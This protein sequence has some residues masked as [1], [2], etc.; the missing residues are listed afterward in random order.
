MLGVPQLRVGNLYL[1]QALLHGARG[2][3]SLQGAAALIDGL[4]VGGADFDVHGHVLVAPL[5][6]HLG[7]NADEAVLAGRDL[8]RIACEVE[9]AVRGHQFHRANQSA[10][11]VP[12]RVARLASVG[13][14]G[15]DVVLAKAQLVGHVNLESHVAIVR[16]AYSG[17]VQ[18]DVARVHDALEVQQQPAPLQAVGRRQMVAIPGHAHLLEGAAAQ[19]ALDV[20]RRVVV[21]GLLAGV[22]RHPG[23]LYLE[24][25]RHVH[26]SPVLV[27]GRCLCPV[28]HVAG[29][30]QP[31]KV[32]RLLN[33]LLSCHLAVPCQQQQGQCKHDFSHFF[34]IILTLSFLMFLLYLNVASLSAQ[35]TM[36]FRLMPSM[37]ISGKP[38]NSMAKPA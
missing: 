3:E 5:H 20:C 12:S 36:S 7:R 1:G 22:R 29:L 4:P 28:G 25:M 27:V 16:S 10:A 30:E 11:R 9:V 31:A 18:E 19:A 13:L 33:A 14:H 6:H 37:G 2:R 34:N 38:L 17:A 23:L 21:V 8:Q 35:I 24:I 32:Q 26:L 15:N